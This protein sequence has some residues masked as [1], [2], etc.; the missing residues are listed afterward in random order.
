LD[1]GKTYFRR[2]KVDTLLESRTTKERRIPKIHATEP[3]AVQIIFNRGGCASWLIAGG[4]VGPASDVGGRGRRLALRDVRGVRG[5]GG[6]LGMTRTVRG[7]HGE[8]K[9]LPA[10]TKPIRQVAGC[11]RKALPGMGPRRN[12]K[13]NLHL[14]T[15]QG[16]RNEA[17]R[18][19][20]G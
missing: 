4:L 1:H 15:W 7:E 5:R 19:T 13:T 17:M 3:P 18:R 6:E 10:K 14:T 2:A 20:E 16:F 11:E 12:S 8:T 9:P